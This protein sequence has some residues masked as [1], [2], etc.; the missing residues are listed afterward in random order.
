MNSHFSSTKQLHQS[1]SVDR[2]IS[3]LQTDLNGKIRWITWDAPQIKVETNIET[4]LGD[5]YSLDY[6]VR[7]GQFDLSASFADPY[8]LR[9]ASKRINSSIYQKG[10]R[11]SC[12]LS[13]VIYAPAHLQPEPTA[14]VQPN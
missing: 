9:I 6:R 14:A 12:S 13:F 8:T 4:E 1:F 2:H 11:Q 5:S 3:S 10:Q 7:K